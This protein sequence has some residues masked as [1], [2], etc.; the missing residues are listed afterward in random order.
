VETSATSEVAPGANTTYANLSPAA[1]PLLEKSSSALFPKSEDCLNL[2][3]WTQP[4]SGEAKKAVMV[5]IH[6]GS[7]TSGSSA[8]PA[9][10]GQYVASEQ[11]VIVV[12]FN[13]RL[14]IFGYPGN[15]NG[16]SNLGILDQRLAIEWV[17]D[18]IAQFG[19][20][21]Q[22]IAMF[23]QSAGAGAVD[24]HS[25]AYAADPIVTGYI[26]QSGTAWGLGLQ[27]PEPAA[28]LW[29]NV[30][31]TVGC[32]NATTNPDEILKCMLSKSATDLANGVPTGG[33]GNDGLPFGPVIDEKIVFSDYPNRKPA[34][35]PVLLG[36]TDNES[37]LFRFLIPG[38]ETVPDEIWQ[39]INAQ[40]YTCPA[41]LRSSLSVLNGNPTWR[42]RWFGAF[43]NTILSFSPF[44][45][46]WHGSEVRETMRS[47]YHT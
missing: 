35:R 15:P 23:G 16:P 32:G 1:L 26:P 37:G 45:A 24:I 20:D 5:F 44:T 33:I 27:K 12:S 3:I 34:N 7:F 13:Y 31:A 38:G 36:N 43:P 2:N 19:G 28:A 18:N 8:I 46:A 40:T 29:Y 9:Y 25:Y 17:R 30:T 14:S 4:Q 10:N 11:D 41:A 21:P 47:M 39:R 42:Y 6:G 22:R